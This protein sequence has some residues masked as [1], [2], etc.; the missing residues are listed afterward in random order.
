M[1][2]KTL[3]A[4]PNSEQVP[5]VKTP[6]LPR[7]PRQRRT[8][9]AVFSVALVTGGGV[10]AFHTVGRLDDR[11]S[12]L[13]MARDVPIGQQIT[14]EDVT[15]AMVK[16]DERLATVEGGQ[17][18]RLIG[19]RAATDLKKGMLV[20]RQA[21]TDRVSPVRGQE[22][23]PVALKPSRL[24]ARGLRPGD[25]VRVVP[26]PDAQTPMP[27]KAEAVTAAV[28]QVKGVDADGLVVVDLIVNAGDSDQLAEQ[29]AAG[30][31]VLVLRSREE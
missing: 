30:Q 27:S 21:V 18:Q 16:A 20:V 1:A 9:M 26:A 22:L 23:V 10:L 3:P 11:T 14:R 17:L 8:G 7:Q 31:V 13:V 4:P 19:M 15:T 2:R 25:L 24:P 5:P 6:K 29:S 28:D 12:V